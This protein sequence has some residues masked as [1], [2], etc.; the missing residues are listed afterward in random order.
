MPDAQHRPASS[1]GRSNQR[2]PPPA[3]RPSA[4]ALRGSFVQHRDHKPRIIRPTHGPGRGRLGFHRSILNP[5]DSPLQRPDPTLQPGHPITQRRVRFLIRST[6]GTPPTKHLSTEGDQIAG[7]VLL[8]RPTRADR[9]PPRK[10][11][12]DQTSTAAAFGPRAPIPL[13]RQCF[14]L[15]R[16]HSATTAPKLREQQGKSESCG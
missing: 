15:S 16:N 4:H 13:I 14:C 11:A 8:P 7:G 2:Q 9:T 1:A 3:P 5:V 6:T 10:V 12:F